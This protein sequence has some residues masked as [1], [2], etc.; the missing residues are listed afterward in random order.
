MC[1]LLV[2]LPDVNVLGVAD[3]PDRPLRIHVESRSLRPRCPDCGTAGEVKDRPEVELV[4]LPVFGRRARLVWRKHRW[5]C[6]HH[7]CPMGSW[8]GED[9]AIAAPRLA[10]TDRA[11]RWVTEQIGRCGRTVNEVAVEL[12]CDW[13][14]VMNAVVAYGTPLVE[15]PDRIGVTNAIGLDETLFVREGPRRRQRWSTSIVDVQAGRLLDVVPGRD[16][17]GPCRW[18]AA[19][20]EEWRAGIAWATLDLSGPYRAVFDTMLPDA[21]QIADPFHLVRLANQK[22]D[23]CRRRVQNETMGHRGRKDDPLYR[24]R[25]LLTKADERL[26]VNGRSRLLGLL[27]AGDPRG[28]VRTAWHAKEVVRALYDHSDPDL[29]VEFVERLGHD[30][31]DE[32]CPIE[33]RS[34]GRTLLRWRDQIAA[35]HRAHVSN[36]PTEAIN[37]LIKRVKRVAFGFTRWRNYRIRALLY[38]GQPNWDLLATLTPR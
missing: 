18:L 36:G 14:T 13:H 2:G 11:G 19:R 27:D 10:L 25:R 23:E 5:R 12:G 35:W 28:E 34:L 15:D 8:T 21:V 4:D 30:L 37:N 22:L 17:L 24:A 26:D 38:A 9:S 32:S 1:E 33:V 31:Q 29:A 20:P 3:Q 7:H 6:R 16:A